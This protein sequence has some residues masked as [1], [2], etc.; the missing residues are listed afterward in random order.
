AA[1]VID[2]A[3]C[4]VLSEVGLPAKARVDRHSGGRAPGVLAI[5]AHI[6]LVHRQDRRPT[7]FEPADAAHE[8]VRQAQPGQPARKGPEAAG[9]RRLTAE[10]LKENRIEFTVFGPNTRV[11]PI[12]SEWDRASMP[13][14][15]EL[16]AASNRDRTVSPSRMGIGAVDEVA[17]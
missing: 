3:A 10:R 7:M 1:E 16:F 12:A 9:A 4:D 11:S 5:Q 8:K 14:R 6:P 2:S 17:M 13:S 15:P